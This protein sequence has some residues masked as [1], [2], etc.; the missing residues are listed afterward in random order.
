M[1]WYD[2]EDLID[3]A[4][5]APLNTNNENNMKT[6]LN[7]IEKRKLDNFLKSKKIEKIE[8]AVDAANDTM[9]ILTNI[10]NSFQNM[11]NQ[12]DWDNQML[13]Y[14]IDRADLPSIEAYTADLEAKLE[15]L[16]VKGFVDSIET[17]AKLV[18]AT[19]STKEIDQKAVSK[20]MG[21]VSQK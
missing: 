20:A 11:V 1:S 19:G 2:I 15:S 4:C 18:W 14:A 6:E 9:V 7:F 17:I 5:E 12:I 13:G 3:T 16:E 8:E 10:A 21:F